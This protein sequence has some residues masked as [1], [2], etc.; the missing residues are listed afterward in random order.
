[1]KQLEVAKKMENVSV[2]RYSELE[3]HGNLSEIQVTRLLKA[4]GFTI[5]SARKFLDSLPP[6]LE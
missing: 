3:N 1:M 5:A 2:Q 4:L 6:P